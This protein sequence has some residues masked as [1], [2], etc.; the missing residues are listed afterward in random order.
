MLQFVKLKWG[1]KIVSKHSVF[2]FV[3]L[4]IFLSL[5]G[6]LWYRDKAPAEAY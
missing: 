4:G 1:K 2:L 5:E 3:Y 6:I